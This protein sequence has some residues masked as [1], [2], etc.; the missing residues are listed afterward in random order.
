MDDEEL[1]AFLEGLKYRINGI[2]EDI[3]RLED[4]LEK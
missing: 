4:E 2:I 3:E 1:K